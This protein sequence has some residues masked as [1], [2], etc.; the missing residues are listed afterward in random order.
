MTKHFEASN[1]GVIMK[2]LEKSVGQQV[3]S[4]HS[5]WHPSKEHERLNENRKNSTDFRKGLMQVYIHYPLVSE[6]RDR[7]LG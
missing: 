7:V 3:E 2:T 6:M 4:T 1:S 5:S